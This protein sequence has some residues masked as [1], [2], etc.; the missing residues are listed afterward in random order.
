MWEPD[1]NEQANY[2]IEKDR[3]SKKLEPDKLKEHIET[4]L[5]ERKTCA[6]ATAGYTGSTAKP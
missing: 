5:A 4:F 3:S 2:W 6:L 1:Y